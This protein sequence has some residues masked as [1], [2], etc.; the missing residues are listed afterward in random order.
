V[1]PLEKDYTKEPIEI[2]DDSDDNDYF[3]SSNSYGGSKRNFSS[4]VYQDQDSDGDNVDDDEN[5]E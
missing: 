5:E 1:G 2:Q 4:E 3:S